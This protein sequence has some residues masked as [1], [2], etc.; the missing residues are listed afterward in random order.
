MY[1][2][3]NNNNMQACIG[4]LDAAVQGA[5]WHQCACTQPRKKKI[6][7]E[8]QQFSNVIFKVDGPM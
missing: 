3:N 6:D 7:I 2:N 8:T 5:I 1:K 4:T